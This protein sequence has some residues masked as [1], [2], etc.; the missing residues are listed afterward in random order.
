MKLNLEKKD[1]IN[2]IQKKSIKQNIDT[3]IDKNN[4]IEINNINN[5]NN[6]KN[7]WNDY[8]KKDDPKSFYNINNKIDDDDNDKY[9]LDEPKNTFKR[10][11]YNY[12]EKQFKKFKYDK[13]EYSKT[14][15]NEINNKEFQKIEKKEEIPEIPEIQKEKNKPSVLPKK[16][17]PNSKWNSFI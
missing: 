13:K 2:T 10:G 16:I 3:D 17:N 6:I 5:N 8:I 15:K 9:I 7:K 1:E 11:R 12:N 14:E 4:K